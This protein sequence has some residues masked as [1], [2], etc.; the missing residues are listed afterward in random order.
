[1][2][3]PKIRSVLIITTLVLSA[4][5]TK[6]QAPAPKPDTDE[7]IDPEPN[8]PKEPTEPET[9]VYFTLNTYEPPYEVEASE[10]W[11]ILH[12]A[13]GK[14]LDYSSY[15]AGDKLEFEAPTDSLTPTFSVTY[16]KYRNLNDRKYHDVTTTT[17]VAR[18]FVQNFGPYSLSES[19]D[20]IKTGEFD[21]TVQNVPDPDRDASPIKVELSSGRGRL[22]GGSGGSGFPNGTQVLTL[23]QIDKYEG[24]DDYLITIL[25]DFNN[26]KYYFLDNPSGQGFTTDYT[27]DFLDFEQD[28]SIFLPPHNSYNLNVAG[29]KEE[30]EFSQNGGYWL[31][32]VISV[33]NTDVPTNPLKVGY[34]DIFTKYRTV[35]NISMDGYSYVIVNFGDPLEALVIPDKPAVT[36]T[37]PSLNAFRFNVDTEFVSGVHS[38]FYEEGSGANNDFLRTTWSISADKG[39]EPVVGDLPNE[40][41]EKY[42]DMA[43]NLLEYSSSR[44]NLPMVESEYPLASHSI[45]VF[46]Q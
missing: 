28:I 36:V 33:L 12:D 21:F 41:L 9:E 17:N 23:A 45:T 27:V 16:L 8:E 11:V 2:F 15:V 24:F 26:L 30:Q 5:C 10:D 44:F 20:L 34:L 43:L 39:F 32:D 18:G 4:N 13:N 25:D 40:I 46:N 22:G 38:W 6:D 31:H 14:L 37:D 29:F 19:E 7:Q 1:M 3:K 42:P 35:F